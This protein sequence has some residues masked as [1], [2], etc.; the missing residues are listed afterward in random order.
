MARSEVP[1]V[2]EE[3]LAE[4]LKVALQA[5]QREARRGLVQLMATAPAT[6]ARVEPVDELGAVAAGLNRLDRDG[7]SVVYTDRWAAAVRLGRAEAS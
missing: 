5:R 2:Q 6:V 1:E 3:E 4:L 7:S